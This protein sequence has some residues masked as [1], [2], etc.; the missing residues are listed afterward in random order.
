[1]GEMEV[2]R[3]RGAPDL[4]DHHPTDANRQL[5]DIQDRM[6]VII[7]RQDW[8]MWLGEATF[9]LLGINLVIAAVLG[10]IAAKLSPS[11]TER[12]ALWRRPVLRH[13]SS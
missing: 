9:I 8:P 6:P 12:E 2:A 1:M 11:H 5:A 4:R 13:S 10:T 7:E 3:R